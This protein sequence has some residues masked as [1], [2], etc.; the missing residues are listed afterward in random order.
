MEESILN[1]MVHI[2]N[3]L[4]GSNN[5]VAPVSYIWNFAGELHI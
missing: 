1:N 2:H 4:F 5:L 3:Q